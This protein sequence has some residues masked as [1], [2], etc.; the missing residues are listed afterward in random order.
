MDTPDSPVHT[1]VTHRTVQ[2]IICDHEHSLP[3]LFDKTFMTQKIILPKDEIGN[4]T[5]AIFFLRMIIIL[6]DIIL[7]QT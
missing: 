1:G 7:D 6:S 4:N 5:S 3:I 2:C